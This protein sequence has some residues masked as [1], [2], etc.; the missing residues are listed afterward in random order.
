MKIKA[1]VN[2]IRNFN[3]MNVP[4]SSKQFSDL[5]DGKSV[6]LSENIA[7]KMLAMGLVEKQKKEKTKKE[8]K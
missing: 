4:C 8:I 5:R 2:K 6:E 3:A 7:N 1:K